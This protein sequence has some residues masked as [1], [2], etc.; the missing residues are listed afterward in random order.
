MM[1]AENKFFH[2]KYEELSELERK[3][4]DEAFTAARKVL[5][6]LRNFWPANDDRAEVLIADITKYYLA[7]L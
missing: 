1:T 7:S 4:I 3:T 6:E 5:C 2:M